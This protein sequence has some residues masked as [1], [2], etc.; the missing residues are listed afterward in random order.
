MKNVILI[1]SFFTSIVAK[2]ATHDSTEN[3]NAIQK[4][5]VKMQALPAP[6]YIYLPTATDASAEKVISDL[7]E[8]MYLMRRARW[9]SEF[10]SMTR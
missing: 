8:K 9:N 5:R 7:T 3:F 2:A 4:S 1:I 10:R 6:Q